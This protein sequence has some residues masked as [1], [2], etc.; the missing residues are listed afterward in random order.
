MASLIDSSLIP[1]GLALHLPNPKTPWHVSSCLFERIHKNASS[2][3]SGAGAKSFT[4]CQV[5]SSDPEYAFVMK[6]FNCSKPKNYGIRNILCVH[7]PVHTKFFESGVESMEEGAKNFP[8]SWK[9]EDPKDQ[10]NSTFLRWKNQTDQFSPIQLATS[11]RA[12]ILVATKVLPLWHGT[13]RAKEICSS[14]F[15]FFGK[16]HLLDK[17]A[18]PGYSTDIGY[19]GS[20]IYF[21][22]SAQYASMYNADKV[23]GTLLLSWVS[24]REP[25]PVVSNVSIPNKGSDMLKL[26]GR[27]AYQNYNCHYIPVTSLD[28]RDPENMVYYPCTRA[29]RPAWDE[30]VV[31]NT[32]QTLARF[33]I[34]LG[35]DFPATIS[36][37][38][39]ETSRVIKTPLSG[40]L[41]DTIEFKKSVTPHPASAAA[42]ENTI[43]ECVLPEMAF[44][45]AQWI[46]FLANIGEDEPPLPANIHEILK[47]PCPFWPNKTVAETHVLVLRPSTICNKPYSLQNLKNALISS[48]NEYAKPALKLLEDMHITE[49]ASKPAKA[50]VEKSYWILMTRDLIPGSLNK[51]YDQQ[52]K[53][54][55]EYRKKSGVDY[56]LAN[57]LDVITCILTTDVST[58][59]SILGEAIGKTTICEETCSKNFAN[60]F[61]HASI[62]WTSYRDKK[63]LYL[64]YKT[65]HYY[66]DNVGTLCVR[67]LSNSKDNCTLM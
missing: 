4:V 57:L 37:T 18:G 23:G 26:E 39:S 5:T 36:F 67:T 55:K 64:S 44:G 12:E 14:G 27:G 8:P 17:T 46:K 53:L 22:N 10:R 7:N 42:K 41:H 25:Y 19:F 38:A 34:E 60:Y 2:E 33:Q 6:Y 65:D 54:I 50:E 61:G 35:V 31:F 45:K 11:K 1:S 29:D 58:G 66:N 62:G 47:S 15:T 59:V 30:Y 56:Q 51:T 63:Y 3:N 48:E 20:G 9:E 40:P 24:M 32:S 21:T 13:N 16:H 43:P 28:P 52:N 49:E